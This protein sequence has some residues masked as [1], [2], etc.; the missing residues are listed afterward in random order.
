MTWDALLACATGFRWINPS[1]EGATLLR[2]VIVVHLCDAV[3]CRL[4]AH[5]NGYSKNL[6]TGLGFVFGLWAVGLLLVLP[7][8]N[9]R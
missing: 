5:N 9:G 6:W 8:R 2:T 1:L 4:F 7:K 3:L